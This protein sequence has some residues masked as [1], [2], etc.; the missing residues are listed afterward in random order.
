MTFK[1]FEA[2]YDKK[3]SFKKTLYFSISDG[4]PDQYRIPVLDFAELLKKKKPEWLNFNFS[5]M[6]NENHGSIVHRVFYNNLED[7]FS[8]WRLTAAQIEEMSFEQLKEYYSKL[9]NVYGYKIPV[10]SWASLPKAQQLYNLG[11]KKGY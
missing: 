5:F 3:P 10:P 2:L 8:S 9:S 1:K 11:E 6:E 7:L 4:D